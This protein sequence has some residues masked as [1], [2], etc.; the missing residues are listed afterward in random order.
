MGNSDLRDLSNL[1]KIDESD[2]EGHIVAVDAY[3]WLYKYLVTTAEYTDEYRYTT[4]EGDVIPTLIGVPRGLQRFF[5]ANLTPVFVFDGGPHEL[6]EDEL[7]D[8]RESREQSANAAEAARNRGDRIAANKHEARSQKIT[9]EVLETTKQLLD[10]FDIEYITAPGAGEAEAAHLVDE[11]VAQYAISDDYDSLL[12]GSPRTVR[13][14]TSSSKSLELIDF[15]AT[16]GDHDLNHEQLV[17]VGILC[18]TDFNEGVYGVGPK[19]AVKG[20]REHGDAEAFL[21]S[22]D[23]DEISNLEQLRSLF[24]NP[25]TAD[26]DP[27]TSTPSPDVGAAREYL[28]DTGIDM[29]EVETALDNIVDETSQKGLEAWT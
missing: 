22:R 12:L 9:D 23:D 10:H 3:N 20:V 17:D 24:L 11:G 27:D 21:D 25:Q 5:R 2:V 16:L 14:F 18:G 26:A 1:S 19:T 6:K 28:E 15:E 29:E 4:D 7:D 13:N 8:R